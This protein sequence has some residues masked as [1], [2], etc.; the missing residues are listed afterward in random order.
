MLKVL[1]L[2][3]VLAQAILLNCGNVLASASSQMPLSGTSAL[4]SSTKKTIATER[5][6]DEATSLIEEE[7]VGVTKAKAPSVSEAKV[8]HDFA[9]N[10]YF[11]VSFAGQGYG[12]L[13]VANNDVVEL[14]PF[15]KAPFDPADGLDIHYVPWRGFYVHEGSDYVNLRTGKTLTDAQIVAMEEESSRYVSQSIIDAEKEDSENEKTSK[16]ANNTLSSKINRKMSSV[17]HPIESGL[18]YADHEVPYSW[19]FKRNIN[20]YP[21]NDGDNCGY[22]AASML[23][24]YN[25]IF[26]CTGYFSSEQASAFIIPYTGDITYINGEARWDGVPELIDSFPHAVWGED[27]A[28]T[29]PADINEALEDFLKGKSVSYDVSYWYWLFDSITPEID[30]GSPVA[31]FGN[32]ESPDPNAG[33]DGNH[34]T[35][36]YGY[37]NNTNLLC[38]FGWD[39]YSQVVMS[40]LGLF[41]TGGWVSLTNHSAHRHNQYFRR[42]ATGSYYCGCGMLMTC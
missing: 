2:T 22:V 26:K 29:I 21:E 15:S 6:I 34:V 12:V 31:L 25:E 3:T 18:I 10:E 4:A 7:L 20:Q 30:G 19:F 16:K 35:V 38:H 40:S 14:A 33:G 11:F 23:L 5:Q 1:N 36:V 37:Y 8:I 32:H 39:G 13:N 41:R 28:G 24:A 42:R 27:T 9:D 17:S